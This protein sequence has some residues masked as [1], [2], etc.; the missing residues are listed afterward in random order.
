ME[1]NEALR[2]RVRHEQKLKTRLHL[3]TTR[4]DEAVRERIRAIMAAHRA[5]IVDPQNRRR[6]RLEPQSYS[7][8]PPGRNLAV[9]PHRAPQGY[10]R[11]A[12]QG[13]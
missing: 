12:C 9:F 13:H 3:A 2:Q 1:T 11:G 4:I 7:P 10:V 6:D 5:G 8:T